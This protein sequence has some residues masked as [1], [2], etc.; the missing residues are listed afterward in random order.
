MVRVDGVELTDRPALPAW[1]TLSAP[2]AGD[3][4]EKWLPK[5][6]NSPGSTSSQP[7]G[8]SRPSDG[9][10]Q[11]VRAPRILVIED[12]LHFAATLRNNLEIEGFIV[13]LATTAIQ[14]HRLARTMSPAL[15]IL[16]IMLF[17][18]DGYDLLGDLRTEGSDVPVIFLTARRDE[19]DK[20]RGFALGA[21]D[22]V[23][24]PVSFAEL[25]AR[26]RAVLRRAHH[27]LEE[28]APQWIRFGDIAVYPPTRTVQRNGVVVSLRPKEYDLLLALMRQHDRIVSR[29]DLLRDV[30]GYRAGTVS[31]TVDTHMA[32]LRQKLEADP[33]NPCHLMTVRT[34][35]YMLRWRPDDVS[36]GEL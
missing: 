35:G 7:S 4:P 16:D 6:P 27:G 17:G 31:R 29:A 14:G 1:L 12:N 24:K 25:L 22:F 28:A 15:I 2:P 26:I 10:A 33:L 3:G 36:P 13:D 8:A 21:D 23:T 9:T 34:A 30:W 20:L 18:R 19:E 32:G 11:A 5:G